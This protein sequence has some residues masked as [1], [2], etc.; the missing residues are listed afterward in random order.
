MVSIAVEFCTCWQWF[1][2]ALLARVGFF[3]KWKSGVV[4]CSV[5]ICS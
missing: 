4:Q 5:H 3:A 1:P 2:A